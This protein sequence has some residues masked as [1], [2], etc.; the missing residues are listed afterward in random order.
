VLTLKHS[1]CVST[2]SSRPWT[3]RRRGPG[4]HCAARLRKDLRRRLEDWRSL[5]GRQTP[6]AR[7]IL[8]KLID[9]RL[10]FAPHP[11]EQL[12][13][14]TGTVTLGNILQ[15]LVILGVPDGSPLGV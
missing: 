4:S 1:A 6:V 5:L 10:V 9:G 8:T 15:G 12:Y 2:N 11:D 7:Q 3:P 14:F 13:R